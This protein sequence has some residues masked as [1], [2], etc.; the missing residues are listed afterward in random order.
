MNSTRL[1]H[2]EKI[3]AETAENE[4]V[5]I[6]RL[7]ERVNGLIRRLDAIDQRIWTVLIAV[8]GTLALEIVNLTM[9]T[10]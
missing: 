4:K 1:E 7:E 5:R 8:C 2:I 10:H 9:R 6:A 3:A